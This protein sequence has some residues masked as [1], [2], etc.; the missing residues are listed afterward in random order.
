[1]E[2][3]IRE[4]HVTKAILSWLETSSWEIVC[5]DFPQSGTGKVLHSNNRAGSKN[6]GSI[7]PD[8]IAIKEGTVVFFENKDRFFLPDFQKLE[9]IKKENN[10]S[11]SLGQLL[12]SYEYNSIY[13]GVGLPIT[14]QNKKQVDD[15]KLKV[16]FII[17]SNEKTVDIYYQLQK[18]F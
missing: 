10:Y 18:I 8:I 11:A 7:I 14:T 1:M 3:R 13:Y 9:E 17:H 6:Q 15:N 2:R 4:E 12:S 16:D 5:F